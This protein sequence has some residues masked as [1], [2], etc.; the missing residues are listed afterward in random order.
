MI[1]VGGANYYAYSGPTLFTTEDRDL[2]LPLDPEN[3]VNCWSACEAAGLDLWAGD[4]PLDFPRDRWLA[5]RVIERRAAVKATGPDALHVDLSL[6]MAGF[7]FDDVW[8][9]RRT[10]LVGG[11]ELH[12]ARLRDIVQSKRAAG[13]DKD[14]LFLATHRE[15]L[16]ELLNRERGESA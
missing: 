1:G 6:V 10:F 2:F 14:R 4:E 16:Q 3:L 11:V 12:V 8:R 13:R 5:E 9:E 15:A 7:D